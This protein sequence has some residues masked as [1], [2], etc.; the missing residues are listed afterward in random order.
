MRDRESPADRDALIGAAIKA[1]EEFEALLSMASG[2]TAEKKRPALISET[3]REIAGII[4]SLP[5]MAGD[6]YTIKKRLREMLSIDPDKTP[7]A[8][9]LRPPPFEETTFSPVE[10][11]QRA[12]R[13]S[14]RPGIGLA[15]LGPP[16]LPRKPGSK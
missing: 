10:D 14:T 12:F 8:M 15:G 11:R 5:L 4:D 6:L 13:G 2:L 16:P 3:L 9:N 1:V 7:P